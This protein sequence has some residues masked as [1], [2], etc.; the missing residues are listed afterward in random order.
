[1][2]AGCVFRFA[3]P[4]VPFRH[5]VACAPLQNWNRVGR[6]HVLDEE[7]DL[8]T[9]V[10][11]VKRQLGVKRLDVGVATNPPRRYGTC[12]VCVG[13]GGSMLAGAISQGCQVFLT[14]EMRHHDV[15]AAQAA[16]CTVLIAGHTNTERGYLKLLRKRLRLA[17]PKTAEVTIAR[18]DGDPL[19][20]M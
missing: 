18:R 15:L 10:D 2:F 16:G 9:L 19:R 1:M 17:L 20:A 8:R 4:L 14:G 5:T 12:G 7:T 13:A 6:L 11:R 3:T